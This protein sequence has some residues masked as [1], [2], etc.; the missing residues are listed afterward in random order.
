MG[1]SAPRLPLDLA[2]GETFGDLDGRGDPAFNLLY[3]TRVISTVALN[4]DFVQ[5]ADGRMAFD[6]AF[7]PYGS[8]RV[9]VTGDAVVDGAG[10]ITLT[11][12]ENAEPVT[13][14]ATGGAGVDHGL[15]ITDTLAMDYRVLADGT[16]VHLAFTSDFGQPFL[17][18]DGR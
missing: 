11:W 15:E 17:N 10:D 5:T 13:L 6:V 18:A 16:G 14:F 4:G 2:A 12:L 7:G 1:L 3:G 9:D 8:D